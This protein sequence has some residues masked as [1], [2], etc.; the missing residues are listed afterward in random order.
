MEVVVVR[1]K[2]VDEGDIS[3]DG[4]CE[5]NGSEECGSCGGE[6]GCGSV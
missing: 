2:R 1:G 4:G 5:G 3:G 6:G